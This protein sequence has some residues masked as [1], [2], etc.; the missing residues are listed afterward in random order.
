MPQVPPPSTL[1]NHDSTTERT[2][3]SATAASAAVP[4]AASI[5]SAASEANQCD[6]VTACT[7]PPDGGFVC[8]ARS[9][10]RVPGDQAV[11]ALA[12]LCPS[13]VAAIA[14]PRRRLRFAR[15]LSQ[16]APPPYLSMA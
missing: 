6:E 9:E 12:G 7:C 3:A 16:P 1:E 11:A 8:A 13:V 5:P 14:P 10:T 4:P 2:E 15:P